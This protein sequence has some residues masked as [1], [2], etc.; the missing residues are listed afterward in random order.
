[1][2]IQWL[3]LKW[4]TKWFYNYVKDKVMLC[5]LAYYQHTCALLWNLSSHYPPFCLNQC[6]INST[7]SFILGLIV[8][9]VPVTL[10][11]FRRNLSGVLPIGNTSFYSIFSPC[12]HENTF[13][14]FYVQIYD[15][16]LK[17]VNWIQFLH[18]TYPE[19]SPVISLKVSSQKKPTN[20][21]I[22]TVCQV[23]F[24]LMQ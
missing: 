15:S 13:L 5:D 12:S 23:I 22:S 14:P 10:L 20:S 21:K 24:L 6:L 17:V 8:Q 4:A 16:R 9:L 19:L 11:S 3:M 2:G 7:A 18:G 1:M